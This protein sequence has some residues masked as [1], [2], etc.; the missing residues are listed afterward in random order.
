[1]KKY[2]FLL[3][4]LFVFAQT[5]AQD[6][7]EMQTLSGNRKH[8]G[9][10][11]ALNFRST[12]I[13]DHAAFLG[14]FK[15]AWTIN[16]IMSMGFEAHGLVP[17]IRLDNVS[18]SR[19]RPLMGYG[20]FFIEP[21]IASNKVIHVTFPIAVGAGWAGY[22]KDWNDPAVTDNK[23]LSDY[24][25]WYIEPSANL[26]VNVSTRFRVGLGIGYR[27]LTDLELLNT[28]KTDFSGITYSLML[29]FGRF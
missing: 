17:N 9:H 18:S 28:N 20:G 23:V 26:E 24:T 2:I 3:F 13:K 29:K 15:F 10:Y 6:K 12:T 1:M 11:F 21:I 27:Y 16:R 5:K 19:V 7:D 4:L 8:S 14:G 22:V 25:F